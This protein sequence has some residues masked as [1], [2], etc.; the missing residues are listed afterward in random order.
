MSTWDEV[1]CPRCSAGEVKCARCR[2]KGYI[3]EWNFFE[4]EHTECTQC[5]G[6]GHVT[7]SKCDGTGKVHVRARD[8]DEDEDDEDDDDDDE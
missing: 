1:D 8:E 5:Q 3:S 6:T 4:R 2:G 7:C